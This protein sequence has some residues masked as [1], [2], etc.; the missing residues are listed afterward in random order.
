MFSFLR[1]KIAVTTTDDIPQG[2]NNLYLTTTGGIPNPPYPGD[3]LLGMPNFERVDTTLSD[4]L[5][6]IDNPHSEILS[7]L[8]THQTEVVLNSDI[9]LDRDNYI[10]CL[11]ASDLNNVTITIPNESK[12]SYQFATHAAFTAF[13]MGPGSL[14]VIADS[15]VSF[16]GMPGASVISLPTAYSSYYLFI[17]KGTNV[18]S[19]VTFNAGSGGGGIAK[20]NVTTATQNM[21]PNTQYVT[22][23]S[24]PPGYVT[25]TLPLNGICQVNDEIIVIGN[26]P[27]QIKKNIGQNQI[28][29][30]GDIQTIAGT[31][32]SN[33]NYDCITLICTAAD[34]SSTTFTAMV[35]QGNV[36]VQ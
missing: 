8:R 27:W 18:W 11:L 2:T 6:N 17:R 23:Y 1:R 32:S 5:A 7:G 24:G 4:H 16:Y 31:I 21:A 30:V 25:F 29:N 19:V 34:A 15:G 13:R 35:D 14:S 10:D 3:N 26:S 9:V 33:T 36:L 28:I 20:V 12:L 22:N